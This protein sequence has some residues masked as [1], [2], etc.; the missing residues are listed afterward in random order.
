MCYDTLRIK[1]ECSAKRSHARVVYVSGRR[2]GIS[3][4]PEVNE[5]FVN[6]TWRRWWVIHVPAWSLLCARECHHCS[7]ICTSSLW[8]MC[9]GE[10]AGTMNTLCSSSFS[11]ITHST[12]GS[13]SLQDWATVCNFCATFVS[14]MKV[15]CVVLYLCL[16]CQMC[17]KRSF[18]VRSPCA[19]D[20]LTNTFTHLNLKP[21]LCSA[22]ETFPNHALSHTARLSHV[23]AQSCICMCPF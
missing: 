13:H 15:S 5:D 6:R 7:R 14:Q 17:F 11:V 23:K 10:R 22:S 19:I 12:A 2:R 8:H 21:L 4:C 18:T 20:G 9:T 3:Y 16:D 1:G